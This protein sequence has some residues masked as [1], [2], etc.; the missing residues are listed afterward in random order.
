MLTRAFQKVFFSAAMTL[1]MAI[2]LT[3][4]LGQGKKE[5]EGEAVTTETAPAQPVTEVEVVTEEPE[6]KAEGEP[7][8]EPEARETLPPPVIPPV[9]EGALLSEKYP[10]FAD[11]ILASAVLDELNSGELLSSGDVVIT[12]AMFREKLTEIPEEMRDNYTP[13]GFHIL[14]SMATETLLNRQVRGDSGAQPGDENWEGL[15]RDYVDK[16]VADVK[17]TEEEM[18]AFYKENT[19][20][21][22]GATFEEVKG[23]LEAYLS[24]DKQEA[25]F[26]EH[27][28]NFGKSVG[29]SL[30]APWVAT[31]AARFKENPIDKALAQGK[32]VLVDFYADWC[33]PCKLMKP[34]IDALKE[35]HADKLTVVVVNVDNEPFLAN[36]HKA[37]SIPLLLFYD[38]QGNLVKRQEGML[39]EEELKK[40]LAKIGV[41]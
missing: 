37:S 11:G 27:L 35:T 17:P 16:V 2:L 7:A 30:H 9:K 13:Y 15:V 39:Q 22:G 26:N 4:C 31:M 34:S 21:M 23:E 29:L 32:P 19:A 14:Q 41:S 33:G 3:A 40:E 8:P 20:M 25:A 1:G 18:A 10:D 24:R 6:A 36:R 38:A 12:E 28:V 5:V